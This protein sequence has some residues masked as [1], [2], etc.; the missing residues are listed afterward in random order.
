MLQ[1]HNGSP[2]AILCMVSL[3]K[4]QIKMFDFVQPFP[5]AP[6]ETEL[7]IDVPKGCKIGASNTDWC[8]KVANNI[9]G[10]KQAVRYGIGT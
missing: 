4:W 2:F 5:Q 1:W 9:Y 6:S 10:Q 7:Y 8:L 3:N